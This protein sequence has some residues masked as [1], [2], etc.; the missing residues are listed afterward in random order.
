M[1]V[2][3]ARKGESHWKINAQFR[4]F[5]ERRDK[6]KPFFLQLSYS[7]PHTPYDAPKVH[8]PRSLTLP[9]FYPDTQLVREYLAA[10]YDEIHRMDSDFGEV[11]RYLDEP[12][13]ER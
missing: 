4:T 8:D 12:R 5:M 3:D 9:P 13:T 1:I 10:Y 2:A 11:L 6:K 7:D